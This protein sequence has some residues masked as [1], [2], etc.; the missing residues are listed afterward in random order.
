M[1]EDAAR[2]P[3][4]EPPCLI[5][6]T[7]ALHAGHHVHQGIGH[8]ACSCGETIGVWSFVIDGPPPDVSC[9]I[10]GQ[11]DVIWAEDAAS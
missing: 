9:R 5:A 7:G 3:D 10:C 1:Y 4:Q 11:P 6:D 2:Q 8:L